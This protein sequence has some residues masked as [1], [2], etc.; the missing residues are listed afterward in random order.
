MKFVSFFAGIGGIDLGLER[1]GHTCVGQVEID[2]YCL[3][4]LAKHWP[5]TWRYHDI[6]KLKAEEIPEA[7][8]W[9]AGFPCQDISNA[10]KRA[11]IRGSRSGLFF[12]WM[13]A[14]RVVRPKHMLLENVA[15][16][17]HRGMGEVC[18]ELA[19]SGYDTEWDCIPAA[20]VGAPHIRNRIF[21]LAYPKG[22]REPQQ[23]TSDARP[24]GRG[25]TEKLGGAGAGCR[26][27]SGHSAK[28]IERQERDTQ[29]LSADVADTTSPRH[30]EGACGASRSARNG[31][32]GARPDG[33]GS[34]VADP[35]GHEQG[36][37][38]IQGREAQ[39]RVASGGG[40]E[41]VADAPRIQP[42]RTVQRAFGQRTGPG[43]QSGLTEFRA[44]IGRAQWAVEPSVCELVTRLPN[45]LVRYAGRVAT[46]VPNRVNKLRALGNAVVPQVA[47]YLGRL[48]KELE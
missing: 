40:G 6:T 43:S 20:A 22:G 1:A 31:T 48:L 13:R 16:L 47:E 34:D 17:L 18:G 2:D 30:D 19:E 38:H 10:G 4:V 32:R 39:E 41:D 37:Q 12:D 36:R 7:E 27:Q 25:K 44:T 28:G 8:L 35:N 11:G 26:N 23:Q 5:D 45:G 29:K 24:E 42:G 33:L 46:G 21:I 3:R 15:A 14:V 9:T